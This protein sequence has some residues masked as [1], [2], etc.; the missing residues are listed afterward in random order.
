MKSIKI[1][2]INESLDFYATMA[3]EKID[4]Y[5]LWFKRTQITQILDF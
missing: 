1:I 3:R 5:F 4:V 2:K